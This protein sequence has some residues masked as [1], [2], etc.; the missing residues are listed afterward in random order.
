MS[1]AIGAT[2]MPQHNALVV[3]AGLSQGPYNYGLPCDWSQK[4]YSWEYLEVAAVLMRLGKPWKLTVVDKSPEVCEAVRK[5][6]RVPVDDFYAPTGYARRFL[7]TLGV[8]DN[9]EEKVKEVKRAII[10]EAEEKFGK[11]AA[12]PDM[13]VDARKLSLLKVADIPMEV[14]DRVT[15]ANTN[16]GTL[17]VP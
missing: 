16:V 14:R 3:G 10:T 4:E 9:D 1:L 17:L 5:Q 15:V 12:D 6:E 8:Y 7:S 11:W 2:S 13:V